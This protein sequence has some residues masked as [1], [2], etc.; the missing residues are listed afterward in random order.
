MTNKFY[1][2]IVVMFSVQYV[3]AQINVDSLKRDLLSKRIDTNYV[4]TLLTISQ[5]YGNRNQDSSLHYAD[6]VLAL[7]PSV[8]AQSYSILAYQY[9]GYAL[10]IKGEYKQAITQYRNMYAAAEKLSD[11][12]NMAVSI[13]NQGNVYIELGDYTTA[14]LKYK[15]A[16][17]LAETIKDEY[18]IARGYNNIGYVYKELGEYEKAVENMLYALKVNE[19]MALPRETA[20]SYNNVAAIYSRQKNLEK[21]LD[22]NNTALSIQTKHNI[23]SGQGIS[24]QGIANIHAE[25]K[26]YA[27][28][29]DAYHKALAL[30]E[31]MQDKRQVA[32]SY[33]NIGNMY[34]LAGILDSS[35]IYFDKAIAL[36]R[37]MGNARNL[38]LSLMGNAATLINAGKLKKAK[39][40]LDS[41]EAIIKMTTRKE[42]LKNY[43]KV[44]SDYH[45]MAGDHK[46]S[47]DLYKKYVD[48]K[49]S[50][51]N[52]QNVKSIADLNI[53]YETEKKQL[54]ILLLNQT[55]SI[56]ELQINNQKLALSKGAYE[57]AEQA[58]ALT[59]ADLTIA[60]NK[61]EIT[62]KNERLLESQLDSSRTQNRLQQLDKEASIQK[63][64][65][66][67]Q[68]MENAQKSRLII[69]MLALAVVL[70]LIAYLSY[71]RYRLLQDQRMQAIVLQEQ[72]YS[73]KS[74]LQAEERERIRI[75]RDL[76]DGVGQMMSAAKMN[77]SA[78]ESELH[79]E[80]AA[81]KQSF[82]R[83]M[84]LI[85]SS[86]A[87]VRSVSHSM[88]PGAIMKEGLAAAL[89]DFIDQIDNRMLKIQLHTE[90]L[91]GR[92]DQNLE[93]VLYRVIQECISNVIKHAQANH[94]DISL[95]KTKNIIEAT[96][97][98]DGK[99]FNTIH[100]ANSNGIGLKNI[101]SRI[102]FLKGQ[103]EWSSTPNKGTL[104]SFQ[105]PV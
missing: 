61:L 78:M 27:K 18:G 82:L 75:A 54:Q 98:D 99:G 60:N 79:F 7:A 32:V 67:N 72:E 77:L 85:D 38:A 26:E 80:D 23:V 14:L 8:H 20:M 3:Q 44:L 93:S 34:N 41:T 95:I 46:S 50:L 66:Q 102:E 37:Q 30:S 65:L 48:Q 31:S 15:E 62:N 69:T 55:N 21:A 10:Y 6:K 100:V 101:R 86:L 36:N 24:L 47:L 12:K 45:T 39:T 52:A 74:V 58:L 25:R 33:A 105:V 70:I 19:R 71:T 104:V 83:V 96:I 73:A 2:L 35:E 5:A 1:L 16:L 56:Q 43:Y 68:R 4:K 64:E 9:K 11:K 91:D 88:M 28:A 90:G 92:I 103:V 94:L 87:E 29:L 76:H 49:D 81:K 97:E 59:A 53:K 89:A 22:Y 84:N 63:L 42:D 17:A 40:L 57:L 51:V 13:N